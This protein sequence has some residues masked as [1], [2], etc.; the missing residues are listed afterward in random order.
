[1]NITFG[2]PEKRVSS[3]VDTMQ[4]GHL[5]GYPGANGQGPIPARPPPPPPPVSAW[6]KVNVQTKS[7]H[8][9]VREYGCCQRGDHGLI[10]VRYQVWVS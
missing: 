1:M 10:Q 8:I 7:V 3:Q 5:D 4:P 6:P 2:V 9:Q